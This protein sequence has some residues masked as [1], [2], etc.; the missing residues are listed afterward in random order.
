M[1]FNLS[2]RLQSLDWASLNEQLLGK[3]FTVTKPFLKSDE[4]KDLKSLFDENE[5]YR[6]TIDMKRYSF[7]R[8]T[9]R[10]FKYP[11]PE[12]IGSLREGIYEKIV[13]TANAWAERSK[14]NIHY[15]HKLPQFI[16]QMRENGQTRSTPI[17]LKYGPADYTCMHQDISDG[18]FFPYQVIFGLSEQG[19]DYEGGQLILLQQR[20][21]L[22]TI[23]YVITIP[24]GAAVITT[25]S[26]HPQQGKRG[27][28][29]CPF[30]HGVGEI[31]SGERY[32]LGIV[33]H[34][35]KEKPKEL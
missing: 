17:I 4:C 23:P 32:T 5:L 28:Y 2:S 16:K 33:F 18:I 34:D 20:P 6:S 35:Y 24:K 7:G 8:G 13:P 9:Y 26:Y 12:M 3:G 11:L 25:S 30:K 29:R 1:S 15:P 21:R 31:T 14:T 22:Q 10:Y 19:R 27:F